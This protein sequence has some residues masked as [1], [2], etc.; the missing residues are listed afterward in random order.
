MLDP[1]GT[2]LKQ[3]MTRTPSVAPIAPVPYR[4]D[5]QP[6][7]APIKKNVPAEIT[8]DDFDEP[9]IAKLGEVKAKG[10][11]HED[12]I[13]IV[14][15][16]KDRGSIAP[17]SEEPK[18]DGKIASGT[19]LIA[20]IGVEAPAFVGRTLAGVSKLGSYINPMTYLSEEQKARGEAGAQM[21]QAEGER[22]SKAQEEVFKGIGIDTTSKM[23]EFGKGITK[24][25]IPAAIPIGG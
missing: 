5:F 19:E 21:V 20:G 10:V 1:L 9:M 7:T 8:P 16:L 24:Y 13:E 4:A 11:Q 6:S 15:A 22:Q 18:D 25:G 14:R 23:G 12:A 17:K 3:G 2:A